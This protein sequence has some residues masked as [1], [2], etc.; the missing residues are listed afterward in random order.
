MQPL[1]VK[2][3][4]MTM[5]VITS[6]NNSVTFPKVRYIYV[7]NTVNEDWVQCLVRYI[8]KSLAD[9]LGW[10]LC[11]THFAPAGTR[12]MPPASKL[13]RQSHS[14]AHVTSVSGCFWV[15]RLPS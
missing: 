7:T 5:Q 13:D 15:Q 14:M 3:P 1:V 9:I 4:D 6:L 2:Q 10:A 8:A 11:N 12:Q